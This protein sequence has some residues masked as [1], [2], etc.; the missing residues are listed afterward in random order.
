MRLLLTGAGGFVGRH[1]AAA[2]AADPAIALVTAG[3]GC[4]PEVSGTAPFHRA[5]LSD[6]AAAAALI[7]EVRP[8]HVIHAAWETGHPGYWH[9]MANVDWVIATA[10]MARSFAQTGGTRFV[11]IG[12]CAE[13]DWSGGRCVEGVT[14][15]RPSTRYGLAKLAAFRAIEAA[16]ADRFEAIE[17]RLFHLYGPGEN[18]ERFVPTICRGHLR[19]AVPQLGSGRH[20]RDLLHAEDVARALLA[21]AKADG[22]VGSVN[23]ASGEEV[24]LGD[25]AL[26]LAA[27]AG[28]A[29]TGLGRREDRPGDPER[30][31]AAP[32]LKLGATGWRPLVPLAEGLRAT[33]DWWRLRPDEAG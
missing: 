12:S 30:L 23:V 20:R 9:D 19:G 28:A 8:T 31:V 22:V 29:E 13:Y 18:P 10:T 16:A 27:I 6:P 24:V 15:D 32:S 33:F 26:E 1:V 17:A 5:D 3:R 11:Q 14:P 21:L 4:S 25:V 2:A 7:A